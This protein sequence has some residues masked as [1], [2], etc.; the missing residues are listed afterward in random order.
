MD[1]WP[2]VVPFSVSTPEADLV[3]GAGLFERLFLGFLLNP[4][5]ASIHR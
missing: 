5:E 4:P 3:L 1:F 2:D